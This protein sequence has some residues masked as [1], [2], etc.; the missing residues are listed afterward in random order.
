MQARGLRG[1]GGPGSDADVYLTCGARIW[2]TLRNQTVYRTAHLS[3]SLLSF[4]CNVPQGSLRSL[5]GGLRHRASHAS[6]T[7]PRLGDASAHGLATRGSA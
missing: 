6:S 3:P 2:F 7:Q 1:G 5:W 4:G